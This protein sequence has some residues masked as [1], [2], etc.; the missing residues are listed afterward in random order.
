MRVTGLELE[1]TK[2]CSAF[3]I[4][5]HRDIRSVSS[6]GTGAN[7]FPD[8]K[9]FS[10][11]NPQPLPKYTDFTN[12]V[13]DIPL[14]QAKEGYVF[15]IQ[16]GSGPGNFGWLVWNDES[17]A[18]ANALQ[19][20]L[21]WPGNSQDYRVGPGGKFAGYQEP[22]DPTDRTLNINDWVKSSTGS[23]NAGDGR[24]IFKEHIDLDRQLRVIIWDNT[25]KIGG[26]TV[27]QITGFAIFRMLG[28]DLDQSGGGSWILAE[29]IRMDN[30]CG[31]EIAQT[32]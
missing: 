23:I 31:Q 17:S 16:N 15:K 10:N 12:H 22:G 30:S 18:N 9:D 11:D 28:Y 29:F 4:A 6:P 19:D 24:D 3:P 14:D 13:P 25:T 27:Y 1:P 32:P 7:P 5:V 2:G 8:P 20:S 21:D 26:D